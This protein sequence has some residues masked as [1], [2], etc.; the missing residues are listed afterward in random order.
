MNNL[1][2]Y[3]L[4]HNLNGIIEKSINSQSINT[5]L[6]KREATLNSLK[7]KISLILDVDYDDVILEQ[8]NQQDKRIKEIK[9]NNQFFKF[10]T[11]KSE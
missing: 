5:V 6:R 3:I 7:T 10:I 1:E 11:D 8:K 9:L 2:N 4:I